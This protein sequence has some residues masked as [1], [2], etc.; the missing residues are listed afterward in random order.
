MI[1]SNKAKCAVIMCDIVKSRSTGDKASLNKKFN[2]VVK[3]QN[4]NYKKQLLSPLTITLGDEFQGLV[5]SVINAFQL[6]NTIKLKLLMQGIRTRFVIGEIFLDTKLNKNI[7]WNMMGTGLSEA[8]E[9]LNDKTD[10]NEYRFSLF[11]K[12]DYNIL[13]N[14]VGRSLTIIERDWSLKQTELISSMIMDSELTAKKISMKAKVG[15]S[16]VYAVLEAGNYATYRDQLMAINLVL[17]K[18]TEK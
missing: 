6:A 5:S 17:N 2:Q 11:N 9:L 12:T 1:L 4:H 3:E 18:T 16:S 7:A 8:R 15:V 10:K 14:A 13:L